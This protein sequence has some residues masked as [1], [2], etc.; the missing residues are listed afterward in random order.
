MAQ[1]PLFYVIW[2]NLV[3][4]GSNYVKLVSDEAHSLRKNVN[5]ESTFRKYMIYYCD[6]RTGYREQVC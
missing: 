4:L 6:I 2:P 3:A 1:W 5:E